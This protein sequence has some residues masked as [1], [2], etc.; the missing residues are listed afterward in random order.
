MA[1]EGSSFLKN[2][3][4]IPGSFDCI[5]AHILQNFQS[6]GGGPAASRIVFVLDIHWQNTRY[7][8]AAR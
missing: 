3:L 4:L 1:V 5:N 8:E 2:V 6:N 7:F